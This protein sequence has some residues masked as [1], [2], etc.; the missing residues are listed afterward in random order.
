MLKLKWGLWLH[1][2][3]VWYV[4]SFDWG[5]VF[6]PMTLLHLLKSLLEIFLMCFCRVEMQMHWLYILEKIQL[7]AH[8]SKVYLVGFCTFFFL[9]KGKTIDKV[10]QSENQICY[11]RVIGH[12]NHFTLGMYNVFFCSCIHNAQLC[13]DVH[14]STRWKLQAG[15]IWKEEGTEGGRKWEG[16]IGYFQEGITTPDTCSSQE[17]KH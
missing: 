8:L 11:W 12:V 14:P 2:T 10:N 16:E 9:K 5:W 17:W 3:L 4:L 7:V 1:F 13:E 15:W 6:T